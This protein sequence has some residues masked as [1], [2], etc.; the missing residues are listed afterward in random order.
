MKALAPVDWETWHQSGGPKYPSEKVV[1]F[2][3]RHYGAGAR[4]RARVLDL[5]CGSGA[6]T[7]FLARE[8]FRTTGTDVSARGLANTRGRLAADGLSAG[9]ARAAGEALPFAAASFDFLICVRVLDIVPRPEA[10]AAVVA[11]AA[12]VLVPGG[13]GLFLLAS[14][15]DYGY[16]YPELNSHIPFHPP[17]RARLSGWFGGRFAQIDVDEYVTTYRSGQLEEHNWLVTVV[18]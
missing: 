15:R 14:P 13:R 7:W 8:G 5:G 10:Q 11:E 2:A 6:N 16:R 1:Q 3:F 9:L 17:D 4:E 18:R 12:R